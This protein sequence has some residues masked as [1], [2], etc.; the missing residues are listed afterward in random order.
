MDWTKGHG[1]LGS[2]IG[3]KIQRAGAEAAEK[4]RQFFARPRREWLGTLGGIL[5]VAL[6]YYAGGKLGLALFFGA[7]HAAPIWPSSSLALAAMLLFGRPALVGIWL[8]A[9]AV[10]C[11][12]LL[13]NH[14]ASLPTVISISALIACGNALEG[15]TGS[16]LCTHWMGWQDWWGKRPLLIRKVNVF[17]FVAIALAMCLPSAIIGP[18]TLSLAGVVPWPEFPIQ[19]FTWWLGDATAVF[20]ITPFLLALSWPITF[21]QNP[22][23][24]VEL[25]VALGLLWL[26]CAVTFGGWFQFGVHRLAVSFFPVV[27]LI[28]IALRSGPRVTAVGVLFIAGYAIWH[29]YLGKGPFVDQAKIVSL[30]LLYGYLWVIG[31]AGLALEALES[32]VAARKEVEEAT[33]RHNERLQL[34]SYC[35]SQLLPHRDPDKIVAD[36]F[37]RVAR[38][39]GADAFFHYLTASEARE[40]ELGN[41]EGIPLQ[42]FCHI[43]NTCSD[44]TL[45]CRAARSRSSV[46]FNDIQNSSD[47][48]LNPVRTLGVQTCVCLPLLVGERLLGI[49]SFAS[50]SKTHF[51][52]DELDFLQLIA[53]YTAIALD[54]ACS[55]DALRERKQQLQIAL[56]AAQMGTWELDIRGKAHA[57]YTD[58]DL[59][60]AFDTARTS[61]EMEEMMGLKPGGYHSA[62]DWER[63]IHPEDKQRTHETLRHAIDGDQPYDIEHRIVWPDGSI[64]WL[65]CRG[66]LF[67][68]GAGR[69]QRFIGVAMDVTERRN[70]EEA[71]R[72]RNQRLQVISDCLT[73]L[74][75]EH[76]PNQ[77]VASLFSQMA[78]HV[79]ADACLQYSVDWDRKELELHA[80]AGI[81]EEVKPKIQRLRFRESLCGIIAQTRSIVA[82][83][84]LPHSS[85]P[86]TALLRDLG[87]QC[88]LGI[89]LMIGDRLL[90]TLCFIAR[91]KQQFTADESDFLR[92][93]SGYVAIAMDRAQNERDVLKAKQAAENANRAKDF[94]LAALSHE[95]R[96]PLTPALMTATALEE[97]E[98]LETPL[99]EQMGVVRH[100][101]ELEARLIDDLLDLTRI[102][103]G[104]FPLQLEEVDVHPLLAEAMATVREDTLRKQLTLEINASA[105]WRIAHADPARLQ[106]VFWNL[107]KN[108]IKFTPAHGRIAIRTYNPT[109]DSIMV[110]FSD[111]GIGI[112]PEAFRQIF[113]PFEQGG[114]AGDHRYGGLGLGL[115]ISKSIVELHKGTLSVASAGLNRGA[116]FSVSLPVLPLEQL[117]IDP[118]IARS[119]RHAPHRH[120]LLVED[121]EQTRT[122]LARLLSREGHEVQAEGTCNG[123]LVA[124]HAQAHPFDVLISDLGLPDGSGLNLVRE[125]KADI[126][127][128]TAI[129]VSGYGTNEDVAR[130]LQAGFCAHLTKPISIE[131]IRRTL[132]A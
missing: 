101:V 48:Q 119:Q 26:I 34:A 29:T 117:P 116:T 4:A 128:L 9:F 114:A 86:K 82:V 1:E 55:E 130:S 59:K 51:A 13:T 72:L 103:R 123:A 80:A 24:W 68:D 115:A 108:A 95:L 91:R 10:N 76:D 110:E 73:Q 63:T 18:T 78:R 79:G 20:L 8:G 23:S 54:R 27:L 12:F 87:F 94:F 5:A 19:W 39:V 66:L 77:I 50:R 92:L 107:L 65:H 33:R 58:A 106:Q 98:T 17:Q 124:A 6:L 45:N 99:R 102:E 105:K 85:D 31:I 35:L 32:D 43:C 67:R 109:I 97:D 7:R 64:H 126:P 42:A 56:D 88:Y 44:G 125:L 14:A 47:P 69:P 62:G 57:R 46:I 2:G 93:L 37:P 74:V 90:A 11:Q 16:Y 38:D 100:S 89:P 127:Q 15:F 60:R 61:P 112:P 111:T 70:A 118:E 75:T 25:V 53:G 40:L 49:L 122:V 121:N 3:R 71:L 28:W 83:N 113:L 21:K 52:P 96:T 104:K 22:F 81:P 132:A 84:D 120:I 30:A 36:I 131:D 41:R 129:A